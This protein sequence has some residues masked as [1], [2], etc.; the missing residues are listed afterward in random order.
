MRRPGC[1]QCQ[2]RHV[3]C[4]REKPRC[5]SCRN[6]KYPTIC[7]Y[8]SKRLRFRQSRYSTTVA[9]AR[10]TAPIVNESQEQP[11]PSAEFQDAIEPSV[12]DDDDAPPRGPDGEAGIQILRNTSPRGLLADN[13]PIAWQPLADCHHSHSS[14]HSSSHGS[15]YPLSPTSSFSSRFDNTTARPGQ[16][17]T[18]LRGPLLESRVT[19]LSSGCELEG[20]EAGFWAESNTNMRWKS[21]PNAG[22]FQ[23]SQGPARILSEDLECKVFGFYITNAGSWL[24]IGSPDRYFQSHIPQLALTEPLVLSACLACASHIMFLLGEVE[25]SVD[26]YYNSRMLELL[27]P[28]LSSEEQATSSNQALLAT[29]V[30]L[31]MSEQFLEVGSDAQRHLNGAASLFMDGITDWSPIESNLAIACFWTHLRETIRI[32]FLREQPCQFEMSYLS[33]A[34]DDLNVPVSSDEA[35]TNRMTYLL[36]RVCSVCW[37]T[38]T[39]VIREDSAATMDLKRLR[40]LIDCW[41]EHLPLS[42][43]PWGVHKDGNGPFPVIRYFASWHVVAWQFYYTARVMLAVYCAEDEERTNLHCAST[44]IEAAVISPTRW[45]CGL[46]MSSTDNIG[47]NLNGSHLMAWCGQFFSGRDERKF[48]LD[49][50]SEFGHRTKWPNQTS[51]E[52]LMEL[53][54]ASNRSWTE[55]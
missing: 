53:W 37:G 35:W 42:F 49:F 21:V 34:D 50:L 26:E 38:S 13:N 28:L 19:A 15:E 17:G 47:I 23:T 40:C 44:Y 48:L 5:S 18:V 30:I 16:N 31:R 11:M 52:R 1:L 2:E 6:A 14:P 10:T 32:C 24:D 54:D 46:C 4:D 36:L 39:S 51:C 20:E 45:L 12:R 27:I 41:K 7:E 3:K 8:G 55:C 22:T 9:V 33:L 43:R 29:T 25:K